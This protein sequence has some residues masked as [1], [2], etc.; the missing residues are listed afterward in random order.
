MTSKILNI[1]L[2]SK[3]WIWKLSSKAYII[4]KQD[5][6]TTVGLLWPETSMWVFC[7]GTL[8]SRASVY[9]KMMPFF[10]E[11]FRR[12]RFCSLRW[13]NAIITMKFRSRLAKFPLI[14]HIR[15]Q[16]EG[17]L[18]CTRHQPLGH[19]YPISTCVRNR[20]MFSQITSLKCSLIVAKT[21]IGLDYDRIN[22]D[23]VV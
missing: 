12:W 16:K 19:R 3:N 5:R 14:C 20:F 7:A 22:A 4:L 21:K 23:T 11:V 8:N 15:T 2:S 6:I 18:L 1:I 10:W 13:I 9:W 17:P